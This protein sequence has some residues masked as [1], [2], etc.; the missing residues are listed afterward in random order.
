MF[1]LFRIILNKFVSAKIF[2]PARS[3][4]MKDGIISMKKVKMKI[5]VDSLSPTG[6][7]VIN[8]I[9]KKIDFLEIVETQRTSFADGVQ[10][11]NL[12]LALSDICIS[13]IEIDA[14]RDIDFYVQADQPVIEMMFFLSGSTVLYLDGN[15]DSVS[16]DSNQH[17][18]VYY[19][20]SGYRSVWPCGKGKKAVTIT[21][22]PE[23]IARYLKGV[24]YSDFLKNMERQRNTALFDHHLNITP[25]MHLLLNEIIANRHAGGLRRLYIENC[26]YELLFLQIEQY[27]ALSEKNEKPVPSVIEKKISGIRELIDQNLPHPYSIS[28]L[29]RLAGINEYHLK[30]SFKALYHQSIYSY[31]ISRRMEKAKSLLL[32]EDMNVNETA[33]MMGYSDSTNFTAAFKKHFGFTPGKISRK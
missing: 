5:K 33:F 12:I 21:I 25:K 15:S 19:S 2:I 4:K 27:S 28:E 18:I 24:Q 17:N 16:I 8:G 22:Y 14:L 20:Q 9:P 26:V 30:K 6:I 32:N 7:S 3:H 31:T 13:N 11:R 29:S 1:F 10:D 23:N